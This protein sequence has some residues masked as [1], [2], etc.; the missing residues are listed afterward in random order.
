MVV[1][2]WGSGRGDLVQSPA[3]PGKNKNLRL[4][5]SQKTSDLEFKTLCSNPPPVQCTFTDILPL[6]AVM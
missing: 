3:S 2:P 6:T 5:V 4:Q 1:V